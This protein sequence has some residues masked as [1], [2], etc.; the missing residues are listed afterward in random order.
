M[1]DEWSEVEKKKKEIAFYFVLS[2]FQGIRALL[3][4][5][6]DTV[7]SGRG[8]KCEYWNII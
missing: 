4:F 7:S 6:S 2:K 8:A 3:S 5:F 1:K